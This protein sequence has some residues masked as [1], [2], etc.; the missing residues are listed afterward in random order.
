MYENFAEREAAL[1]SQILMPAFRH[2]T[3]DTKQKL[4]ETLVELG[5]LTDELKRRLLRRALGRV[6]EDLG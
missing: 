4:S 2:R 1:F 6:F 3:P 5:A